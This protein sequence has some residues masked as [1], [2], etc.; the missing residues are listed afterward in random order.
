MRLEREDFNRLDWGQGNKN[1]YNG[2]LLPPPGLLDLSRRVSSSS[3]DPEAWQVDPNQKTLTPGW[4]WYVYERLF[5]DAAID[6]LYI[7]LQHN[8]AEVN[9]VF[10]LPG[11][12]KR[13][14]TF[15]SYN[16]GDY[17]YSKLPR[18][19][20][21]GFELLDI[22]TRVANRRRMVSFRSAQ[23]NFHLASPA[24]LKVC[25]YLSVHR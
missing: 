23:C 9:G 21:Y 16:R 4:E 24:C 13:F 2:G 3:E 18:Q 15:F 11:L 5:P 22:K 8:T 1:N 25:R 20:L 6:N 14:Y 10:N 17:L 7:D 19:S 12:G